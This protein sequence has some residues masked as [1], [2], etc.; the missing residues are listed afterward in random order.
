MNWDKGRKKGRK[1]ENPP[2]AG[3]RKSGFRRER[4]IRA[5]STGWG[6]G[7]FVVGVPRGKVRKGVSYFVILCGR[8]KVW[9]YG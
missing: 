6:S 9:E 7:V 3:R 4:K 2:C 8:G 1:G 5:W